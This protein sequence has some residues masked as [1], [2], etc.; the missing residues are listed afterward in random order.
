M[1]GRLVELELSPT[2]PHSR[3]HF[4]TVDLTSQAFKSSTSTLS[5]FFK[6]AKNYFLLL[7]TQ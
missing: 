6:P 3:F 2:L 1:L 7:I 5:L 4:I